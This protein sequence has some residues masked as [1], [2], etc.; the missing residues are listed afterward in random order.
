MAFSRRTAPV[1]SGVSAQHEPWALFWHATALLYVLA[2]FSPTFLPAFPP[3][4]APTP[5]P[6]TTPAGAAPITRKKK[7]LAQLQMNYKKAVIPEPID[8]PA[9][10][11]TPAPATAPPTMT[12]PALKDTR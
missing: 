11:P 12:R 1:P 6:T 5:P 9:I 10:T 8:A 2:H 4:T 7:K 3:K